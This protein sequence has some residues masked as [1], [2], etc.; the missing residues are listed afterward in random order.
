MINKLKKWW[1]CY[2]KKQILFDEQGKPVDCHGLQ[3]VDGKYI[4][5]SEWDGYSYCGRGR[6]IS[7]HGCFQA[8]MKNPYYLDSL[9]VAMF[10]FKNFKV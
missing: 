8:D 5:S 4:I 3:M 2:I 9:R 6:Y 7:G 1:Y 10:K